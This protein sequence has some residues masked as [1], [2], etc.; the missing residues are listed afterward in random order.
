MTSEQIGKIIL[1]HNVDVL[2]DSIDSDSID[3][4]VTSPPYDNLRLYKGFQFDF[5]GVAKQLYRVTKPGGVVVWVVGDATIN[6]GE[7]GTSFRQALHFMSLGFKLHDT[8][9]YEKNTST[10]PSH[11]K[12]GR[13]TQ[14]FEYMF[15]LSKD[16]QPKTYNLICDKVN[17][18]AG[19]KSKGFAGHRFALDEAVSET[20][21]F[22]VRKFGIRNNIW[23]FTIGSSKDCGASQQPAVFPEALA[24]DHI[25]SWSNPGD[26]VL[27]PFSGSG[28][29]CL[30]A[31]ETKRRFIGIEICEDYCKI[32]RKR[33]TYD[34]DIAAKA[35]EISSSDFDDLLV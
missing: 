26:L 16:R 24:H 35:E 33:L 12:R 21:D 27:D 23:R 30:M 13:Y 22:V 32:A 29:T 10:F 14:I 8:M 25:I 2:R 28:T 19:N 3:L 15:V 4:T 1:G 5:E 18:T 6:K 9:I 31:A 20:R 7:S 17:K 34:V 11:K